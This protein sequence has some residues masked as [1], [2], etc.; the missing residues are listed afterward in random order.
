MKY[1]AQGFDFGPSL[2][3][4][5]VKNEGLV[6]FHDTARAIRLINS[7]LHSKNENIPIMN[8]QFSEKNIFMKLV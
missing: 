3:D 7:L 6:V 4:P 1:L 5:C 2:R 8:R